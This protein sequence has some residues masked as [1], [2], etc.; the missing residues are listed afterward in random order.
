MFFSPFV[1]SP[2]LLSNVIPFQ[3]DSDLQKLATNITL[4]AGG[5]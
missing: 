1:L 5:V 2:V 4:A 3:Q